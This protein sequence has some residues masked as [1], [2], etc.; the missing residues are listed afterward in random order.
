[1]SAAETH[2]HTLASDGMVSA[3][4]L[5]R[6]AAGAGISVLAVTDHDTCSAFER[7]REEGARV[8]V[9]VIRGEEVTTALP[10]GIHVIGLFL[11]HQIRMGMS[12]VDTVDAIHAQGGLAV[13]PHPFMPTFFASISERRAR[14]LLETRRVDGIELLHTAVM[15]PRGRTRLTEFY[16][17]HRERLGAA[18]GAGDSHFGEHDVGRVVTVF[19]GRTAADLRK[20][21]EAGATSPARG[22][23]PQG[24]P[25]SMRL[26]QQRRSLLW[27]PRERRAGRVGR[28][29]GPDVPPT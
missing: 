29:A 15:S 16:G 8:G 23:A 11:E 20:A 5:G 4:Q 10:A 6:A 28:G 27:L 2:A 7:A 1:M 9:D 19:E 21:I 12:L 17:E 13:L 25:L 22:R 14:R 3:E 18:L 24:P 26:A